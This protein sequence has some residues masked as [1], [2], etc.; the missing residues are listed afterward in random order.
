LFARRL[1]T[2]W[3]ASV[4]LLAGCAEGILDPGDIALPLTG[5]Y[6]LESRTYIDADRD[7]TLLVQTPPQVRAYLT[8]VRNGRYGQID[9]LQ[10]T[11]GTQVFVETGRW[12]VLGDQFFIETDTDRTV[13][14]T[15]TYDGIYLART[16]PDFLTLDGTIAIT[17]V[18]RRR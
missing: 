18:W 15:F 17:D 16:L 11:S 4:L 6:T 13:T 3:I 9:T 2:V 10:T 5:T 8:L 1:R 12:S 7:S 14:E